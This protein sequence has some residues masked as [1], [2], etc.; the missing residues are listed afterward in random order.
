MPKVL[1]HTNNENGTLC[2]TRFTL[3]LSEFVQMVKFLET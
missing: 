3:V 2:G 1:H